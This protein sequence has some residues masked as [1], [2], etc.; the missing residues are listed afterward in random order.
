MDME[1]DMVAAAIS[2]ILTLVFAAMIWKMPTW[3]TIPVM[4]KAVMTIIMP[5]LF[6]FVAKWR[7]SD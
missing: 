2:A 5:F 1:F 7:L 6:Y 4:Q 3:D